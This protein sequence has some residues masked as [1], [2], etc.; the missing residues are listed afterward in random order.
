[1][2]G[3]VRILIPSK[4]FSELNSL[5]LSVALASLLTVINAPLTA[6]QQELFHHS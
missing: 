2:W 1:M 6:S 5:A 3:E 4:L